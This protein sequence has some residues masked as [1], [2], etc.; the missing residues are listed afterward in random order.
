MNFSPWTVKNELFC[1]IEGNELDISARDLKLCGQAELDALLLE[2]RREQ[3][4]LIRLELDDENPQN[5]DELDYALEAIYRNGIFLQLVP[6]TKGNRVPFSPESISR[7]QYYL[8]ELFTRQ[9]KYSGKTIPEY[10]NVIAIETIFDMAC[11]DDPQFDQYTS[12]VLLQV[13]MEHYFGGS[14]LRIYSLDRGEPSPK[15]REIMLANGMH[16]VSAQ[17]Y[18]KRP[19]PALRS[20]N[21]LPGIRPAVIRARLRTAGNSGWRH[22]AVGQTTSMMLHPHANGGA[23]GFFSYA[24]TGAVEVHLDFP[25]QVYSAIFRPSLQESIPV[26]INGKNVDFTLPTPRYG[27]LEIN[28]HRDDAAAYTVY[29]LGD[30]IM[31]FEENGR[32]VKAV[33]P[34][35]HQPEDLRCGDEADVLLFLPGLHDI[36]GRLLFLE[37]NKEIF[38]ER[39]AVIRSGVRAEQVENAAIRGQGILD[40]TRCQRDV[41]ENRG[42]R[43]GE[44][45]IADAGHEGFICFHRGRNLAYDGPLVYNPQFWNFVISGVEHCTVRNYKTIS[46]IL[47]NDG[48]QP[49]SCIDLRV[50]HCFMKCNDDCVAIK[51]RRSF[52][53][54]SGHLVFRDL[55]LWNDRCGC[56]LEIGHTSQGDLLEDILFE[57]IKVIHNRHVPIH[58]RIIDHSIVRHVRYNRIY[59]EGKAPQIDFGFLIAPSYY[60]TDDERGQIQDVEVRNYYSEHPH[61][62]GCIC[63]FDQGHRV[64]D[65]VFRNIVFN[66]RTNSC[67]ASQLFWEEYKFAENIKVIQEEIQ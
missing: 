12:R 34:G 37:S 3:V 10:E 55:V 2:F 41:G 16:L 49:R 46:W 5:T 30:E 7:Q 26:A 22:V 56:A 53:M 14:A 60:T 21:F 67:P 52:A 58:M 6:V 4:N 51:T 28:Y 18:A 59:V 27:T 29:I 36:E 40:G 8:S 9:N 47:N 61:F 35:L 39:G 31:D 25:T 13:Y 32:R 62:P 33:S 65:I 44:K 45:W 11:F 54:K 24:S 57:D 43:M 17:T 20:E 38:L 1:D 63:G 15:R 42:N 64:T 66:C 50:E 23:E 48:I 19:A